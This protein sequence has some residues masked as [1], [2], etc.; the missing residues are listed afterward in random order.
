MSRTRKQR[1]S[2]QVRFPIDLH[3]E[4]VQAAH[5]RDLSVN[6]LV[7]A[8]C[9]DFLARLIPADQLTLTRKTEPS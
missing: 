6:Y 9:R 4:L 3:A 2:T 5:D 1:T 7:V 8:A